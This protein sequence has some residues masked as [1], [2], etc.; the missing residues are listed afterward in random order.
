MIYRGPG[1]EDGSFV[2]NADGELTVESA[3][4]LRAALMDAASSKGEVVLDFSGVTG[5]D[6]SA[7]QLVCSACKS[8]GRDG[9]SLRLGQSSR[10]F[11]E[12][13]NAAGF[14]GGDCASGNQCILAGGGH[15]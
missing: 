9:W 4:E 13:A 8:A 6:L 5:A 3:S 2:V 10:I 12:V 15:G 1:G 11:R 7:L 14:G